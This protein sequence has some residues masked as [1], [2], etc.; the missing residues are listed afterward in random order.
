MHDRATYR[1]VARLHVQNLDQSFLATLGEGF[2]T[3]LYRAMDKAD[4]CTLIVERIDGDVVGFV[5]GGRAMGPIYKAMIPRVL[6]W[7]WGLSLRL[8]SPKRL[9]RVLDILRYDGG[10]GFADIPAELFSIA[11]APSAR[12]KGVAP[13]LYARLIE[14]FT[15]QDIP[16][17]RIIV[18][19]DLAPAHGFYKKMGAILVG[20]IAL[21]AGEV[22]KV[23]RQDIA[24][25]S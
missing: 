18:G 1:A 9:K 7:G 21:H 25:K 8:L 22:S 13:R 24:V 16:A 20:D 23:Y 6:I 2:L 14:H 12:G 5:T 19:G 4:D 17:F 11:V 3:E 15:Q 10:D